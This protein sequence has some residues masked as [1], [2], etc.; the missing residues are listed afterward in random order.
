MTR[1]GE[2]Y[3]EGLRDGRSVWL[4]GERVTDV[5]RSRFLEPCAREIARLYDMQHAPGQ[6]DVLTVGDAS[7]TGRPFCLP[8]CAADLRARG[9]AY[10]VWA[11][12]S[13]GLLGR[14]PDYMATCVSALASASE[15][16]GDS[17]G[18]NLVAYHRHVRDNDLFV[19]HTFSVPRVGAAVQGER[20]GCAQALRADRTTAAGIIVNG[21]RLMATMSPLADELVVMHGGRSLKEGQQDF[22]IGFA[23]PINTPGVK[24]ICRESY[25]RPDNPDHHPLATRFD[26]IDATIIFDEVLVP[27]DRVFIFRDIQRSNEFMSACKFF[28]HV[29]QQILIRQII[30]AEFML[31]V[32]A[33][34]AESSGS[35]QR[36]EVAERLGRIAAWSDT[37]RACLVA[38]ES[39]PVPG[40]AGTVAPG[41]AAIMAGLRLFPDCYPTMVEFLRLIGAG[42]FVM[43]PSHAGQPGPLRDEIDWYYS[44]ANAPG[45]R[46]LDLHRLGWEMVGDAFG[47]RQ[48]MFERYFLGDPGHAYGRIYANRRERGLADPLAILTGGDGQPGSLWSQTEWDT[49]APAGAGQQ[50]EAARA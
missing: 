1:N 44:T 13:C 20:T 2:A 12:A 22:A 4:E 29:G 33:G 6:R 39:E 35:A 32:A 8:R 7:R 47:A 17:F 31:A 11:E 27:W 50:G 45:L 34:I 10:R 41:S 18:A 21:A 30:K 40:P 26:E 28:E 5:T 43:T 36:D 9:G 16:F 14:T 15:W 23:L 3:L 49:P 46:R 48:V 37:L 38:G 19:A 42:G 24:L 25:A